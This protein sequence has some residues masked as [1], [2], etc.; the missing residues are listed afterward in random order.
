MS[1]IRFSFDEFVTLGRWFA[2][3]R[4]T[5]GLG[6]R[7]MWAA[8]VVTEVHSANCEAFKARYPREECVQYT[9]FA[10]HEAIYNGLMSGPPVQRDEVVGMANLLHYNCCEGE[11]FIAKAP[12][13]VG[14]LVAI[15][16]SFL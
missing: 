1:V 9:S 12:E 2:Q 13:R 14:A 3:Q 5:G 11:D 8:S 15:L 4:V 10:F 7:A 16:S 6:E